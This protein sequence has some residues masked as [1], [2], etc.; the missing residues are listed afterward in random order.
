MAHRIFGHDTLDTRVN[1]KKKSQNTQDSGYN[2]A[3]RS[4]QALFRG[5]FVDLHCASVFHCYWA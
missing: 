2:D 3:Y 1:Y 5:Y 4:V